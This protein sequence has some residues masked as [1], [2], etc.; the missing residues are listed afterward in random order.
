MNLGE[1]IDILEIFKAK[2]GGN[3][4]VVGSNGNDHMNEFSRPEDVALVHTDRGKRVIGLQFSGIP[5]I[6]K[7]FKVGDHVKLT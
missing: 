4:P 2:Y 1:F 3:I 6:Q 5:Y 7:H